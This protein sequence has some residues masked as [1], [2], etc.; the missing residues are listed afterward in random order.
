MAIRLTVA[1]CPL[2]TEIQRRVTDA[3]VRLPGVEGIR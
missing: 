1:G 3:L 2:K